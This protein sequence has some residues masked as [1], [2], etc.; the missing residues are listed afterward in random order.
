AFVARRRRADH[1]ARRHHPGADPGALARHPPGDGRLAHPHH[2]RPRRGGGQ[3][4][5]HRGDVR[6]PRGGEGTVARD[7]RIPPP[8]LHAGP[9]RE[10]SAARR[11]AKGAARSHSRAAARSE[12]APLRLPLPTALPRGHGSLRAGVSADEVRGTREG[13]RMLGRVMEEASTARPLVEVEDLRVHFPVYRGTVLKRKAAVVRAV[14]GVSFAIARGET[15]GLVGESGCGKSTTG[16]ALMR[17]V[18]VTSGN[19]RFD[20]ED[21]L[22]LRGEVLRRKRRHFQMIF[23]DPYG[24]LDPRMT[25]FDIVAEPL[26]AH[27]MGGPDLRDRVQSMLERCGMNPR[28]IRR[29]PHEFSG[30]QRQRVAIARALILEPSFVV[31]DE[32]VSALDVSI[33]AQVLNLLVELQR[34]LGLTYLF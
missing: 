25:V 17:L 10:C 7:L 28:Y 14:D 31:C 1:R 32:P 34:D 3:R 21:L 6:G 22:S 15:L 24:S 26:L 33:R 12:P 29:Y 27:G 19:I 4:R 23:Q 30:G 5:S 18:P 2:P 13:G 9:A 16:R 11:G 8:P 20:G